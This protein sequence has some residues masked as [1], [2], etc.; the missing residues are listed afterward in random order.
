MGES[1]HSYDTRYKTN[2]YVEHKVKES[3]RNSIFY[4]GVLEYNKRAILDEV[5][6]IEVKTRFG[7][8]I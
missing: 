7:R 2:F 6:T 5:K 3:T 8:L 4:K 1:V